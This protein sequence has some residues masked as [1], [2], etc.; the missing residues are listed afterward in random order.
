LA[1][2]SNKVQKVVK[3]VIIKEKKFLLQLRDNNPAISYPNNWA[4]FGGGVDYGEKHE[5]A[6][7]RELIEEL[8]WYPKK[9]KY[10]TEYRNKTVNCNITHYLMHYDLD[11]N[12][13]C[14]GEGQAMNWFSSDEIMALNN[15]PDEI[16]IVIKM[17]SQYLKNI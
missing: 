11:K 5:E 14:L 8:G 6:L 10:L 17:A 3:A 13:L 1:L 12:K 9:F 2:D 4:F 16:E 15:K 7:K